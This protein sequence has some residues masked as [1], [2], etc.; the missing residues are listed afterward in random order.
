[1]SKKELHIMSQ[2]YINIPKVCLNDSD[3]ASS[4]DVENAEVDIFGGSVMPLES[5]GETA[6]SSAFEIQQPHVHSCVDD[7]NAIIEIDDLVENSVVAE[8]N[9]V[10]ANDATLTDDQVK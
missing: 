7:T 9:D 10:D 2:D 4:E 3:S 8:N 5:Q 6:V 1:M